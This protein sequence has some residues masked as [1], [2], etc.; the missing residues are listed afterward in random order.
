MV[1]NVTDAEAPTEARRCFSRN[2]ERF[3]MLDTS[4]TRSVPS[5][6]SAPTIRLCASQNGAPT[7]KKPF[8][9][10]VEVCSRAR[11]PKELPVK[12]KADGMPCHVTIERK[13]KRMRLA[14]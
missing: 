2:F 5:A 8:I 9:R 3:A 12:A 6:K 14:P 4:E 7:R 11:V 1:T 10:V 13:A